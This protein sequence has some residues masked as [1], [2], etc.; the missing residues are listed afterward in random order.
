MRCMMIAV[1]LLGG[2]STEANHLGNPALLPFLAPSTGLG[3]AA[4][5]QRRGAVEVFVKSN[6]TAI[7]MDIANEGGPTLSQAM[8]IAGVPAAD[9]PARFIQLRSDLA[10]YQNSPDALVVALMVYA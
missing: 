9:R 10:L 1:C 5:N 3:N 7:L 4:Y 6:Y 2:C 8:D